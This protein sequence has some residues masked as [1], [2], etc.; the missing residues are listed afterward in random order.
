MVPEPK[1]NNETR[2]GSQIGLK[3]VLTFLDMAMEEHPSVSL[4]LSADE[5]FAELTALLSKTARGTSIKRF[6]PGKGTR[7]FHSFEI[8]SEEGEV[9]GSLN[10]IYLRKPITSYYLVYVK[11]YIFER[12]STGLLPSIEKIRNL[13][14]RMSSTI[15]E[16]CFHN[17]SIFVNPPLAIFRD[18]GN[19]YILRKKVGGIHIDEALDQLRTS[20]SLKEMNQTIGIDRVLIATV[21]E[22]NKWL[23]KALGPRGSREMEDLTFFVSWDVEKNKPKV[24]V[25]ASGV[26]F[27]TLWIA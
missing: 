19:A 21:N 22:V 5:I 27:D 10:M 16:T 14:R 20:T 8:H 13:L 11:D 6:K 9:L 23:L 15:S 1:E 4:P 18:G 17:T 25:D 26:S 12:M 24:M 7:S 3:D 2:N